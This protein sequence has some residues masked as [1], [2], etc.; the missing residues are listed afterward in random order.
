MTTKQP[1]SM[2][3]RAHFA[4]PRNRPRPPLSSPSPAARAAASSLLTTPGCTTWASFDGLMIKSRWEVKTKLVLTSHLL[5]I[6]RSSKLD[7]P[8]FAA[9]S[10]VGFLAEF[11]LDSC[12]LK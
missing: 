10:C 7:R 4:Q 12:Y 5:F 6:I 3:H 9:V 11:S 8:R 1:F 2:V